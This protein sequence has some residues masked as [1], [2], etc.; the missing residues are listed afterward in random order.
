M[1][2]DEGTDKNREGFVIEQARLMDSSV[3][4]DDDDD[5]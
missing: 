4:G 2:S 1:S 5:G 3:Y